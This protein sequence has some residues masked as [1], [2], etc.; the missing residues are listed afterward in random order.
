[1]L[2]LAI[3]GLILVDPL[4][5]HSVAFQ[6]SVAAS[7]GILFWSGRVAR[8]VPGPRVLAESLAVTATAQLAVAP[9]LLWRFDGLPVASLP[10]NL[11]AGP[12]AG[13]VMMWGLTGGLLAGVVPAGVASV[14]HVPTKA[15]VWWIDSVAALAPTVPLGQLGA[16]HVALLFGAGATGLRARTRIGRVAAI[17]A[18]GV[19]LA[20]PALVLA[21]SVPATVAIDGESIIWRDRHTTVVEVDAASRPEDVLAALRRNDVGEIDAVVV[22]QSSYANADLVR[23]VRTRHRVD[24]V[25][26]PQAT[27]G[28]GEI[29]PEA[30]VTFALDGLSV[31]VVTDTAAAARDTRLRVDALVERGTDDG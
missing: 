17:T 22:H 19:T 5:V 23:S 2:W 10:A 31:T 29:V 24:T 3:A 18:I 6:L 26:A 9:L 8:A 15:L 21:A 27:M 20:Q 11:L 13:P 12:A 7:A 28:V 16:A 4:I 25:L 14:M 1:V 30:S